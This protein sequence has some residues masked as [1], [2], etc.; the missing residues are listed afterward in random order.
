MPTVQ[1][2]RTKVK[3]CLLAAVAVT[4][5]LAVSAALAAD[6]KTLV[7]NEIQ[8]T[9][10][11][12]YKQYTEQVPATLL[13]FGC[14]YLVKGGNGAVLS[15]SALAGRVAIVECPSRASA[16]AWHESAAYQKILAI[17]NASS[18][19]RVY[20]VDTVAP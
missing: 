4:T 13:P 1:V 18:T 11:A 2:F 10:A 20:I 5:A 7:V 6:A 19:S 8:I 14:V 9:D 17:R 16:L 12:M 3:P 15:G